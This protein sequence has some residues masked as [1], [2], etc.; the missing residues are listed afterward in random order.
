MGHFDKLQAKEFLEALKGRDVWNRMMAAEVLK[1]AGWQIDL[2]A[3]NEKDTDLVVH[4]ANEKSPYADAFSYPLNKNLQLAL[5]PPKDPSFSRFM[6]VD[7]IVIPR[8]RNFVALYTY[9][10]PHEPA[11]K[12]HERLKW[13]PAFDGILH[14]NIESTSASGMHG[15]QYFNGNVVCRKMILVLRSPAWRRWRRVAAMVRVRTIALYWQERTLER[16]C[17]PGGACRAR[18]LAAFVGDGVFGSLLL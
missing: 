7:R 11:C 17:A 13:H 2:F 15:P 5:E 1:Q 16:T 4:K 14:F 8:Y 3:Q 18:D 6:R 9:W 12:P 10:R